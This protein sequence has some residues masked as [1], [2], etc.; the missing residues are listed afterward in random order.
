MAITLEK[1]LTRLLVSSDPITGEISLQAQWVDVISSDQEITATIPQSLLSRNYGSLLEADDQAVN[2]PGFIEVAEKFQ[3][4]P[5]TAIAEL[6]KA[7]RNYQP[8]I[9]PNLPSP[10]FDF[11]P[12]E[13]AP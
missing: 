10:P 11:P 12:F 1:K 5:F 2:F 7:L 9:S 13:G 6:L 8:E 3:S 4:Q